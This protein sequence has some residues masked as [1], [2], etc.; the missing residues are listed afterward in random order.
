MEGRT[1]AQETVSRTVG[2]GEAFKFVV[3]NTSE[4]LSAA[5][6]LDMTIQ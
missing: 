5:C 1:G 3:D 4:T 6:T 2:N